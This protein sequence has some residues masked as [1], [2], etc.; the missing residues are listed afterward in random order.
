MR[1]AF[2]NDPEINVPEDNGFRPTYSRGTLV[3]EL[4]LFKCGQH[5]ANSFEE[6]CDIILITNALSVNSI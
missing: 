4:P 2:I 6:H 5:G 3:I 1:R